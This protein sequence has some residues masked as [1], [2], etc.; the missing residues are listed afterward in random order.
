[1]EGPLCA[2][3]MIENLVPMKVRVVG[4]LVVPVAGVVHGAIVWEPRIDVPSAL[5]KSYP[6]IITFGAKTTM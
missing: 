4:K 5:D 3:A 1:M 2:H 6:S